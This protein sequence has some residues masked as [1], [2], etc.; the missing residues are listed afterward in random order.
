VAYSLLRQS[1]DSEE[2]IKICFSSAGESIGKAVRFY[3][4]KILA[5]VIFLTTQKGFWCLIAEFLRIGGVNMS[6][7]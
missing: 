5:Y 4:F 3:S 1:A 2:L 6:L 7:V